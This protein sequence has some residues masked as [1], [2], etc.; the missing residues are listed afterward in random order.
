MTTETTM[1]NAKNAAH[2][3]GANLQEAITG[4]LVSTFAPMV[5]A[6]TQTERLTFLSAGKIT[7]ATHGNQTR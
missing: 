2:R 1:K 6:V 3:S 7:E 4:A 5:V